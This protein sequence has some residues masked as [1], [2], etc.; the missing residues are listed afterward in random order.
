ME[1][2]QQDQEKLL[3]PT[4]PNKTTTGDPAAALDESHT[5]RMETWQN[6]RQMDADLA[7]KKKEKE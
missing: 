7:K 1:G 3:Q 5:K 4:V 6:L 2:N